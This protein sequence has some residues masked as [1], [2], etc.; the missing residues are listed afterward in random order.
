MILAQHV[1]EASLVSSLNYFLFL[2]S[3]VGHKMCCGAV[4]GTPAFL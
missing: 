3:D 1:P 2:D 4:T